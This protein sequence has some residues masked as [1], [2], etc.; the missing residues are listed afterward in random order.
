MSYTGIVMMMSQV[1][2][3]LESS[4]HRAGSQITGESQVVFLGRPGE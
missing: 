3:T 2:D 1:A 4:Q